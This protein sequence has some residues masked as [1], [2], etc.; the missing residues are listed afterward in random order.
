MRK[1]SEGYRVGNRELK[2]IWDQHGP[3]VGATNSKDGEINTVSTKPRA[4]DREGT[5]T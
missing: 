3:R 5:E 2:S 4:H 1:I